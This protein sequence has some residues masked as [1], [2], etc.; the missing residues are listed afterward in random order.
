MASPLDRTISLNVHNRQSVVGGDPTAAGRSSIA[1]RWSQISFKDRWY[2]FRHNRPRNSISQ[3][4][5]T[6]NVEEFLFME[7]RSTMVAVAEPVEV[8]LSI[9]I[10]KDTIKRD[11]T[12]SMRVCNGRLHLMDLVECGEF[13]VSAV[14]PPASQDELDRL[15]CWAVY[16]GAP[17]DCLDSLHDNGARVHYSHC[18]N[19]TATHVAAFMGNTDALR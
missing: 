17:T 4:R 7:K 5:Q 18:G 11:L 13:D 16:T 10:Q 1:A 2:S 8:E 15:L 19:L 14:Q 12:D 3:Q 9:I 6:N